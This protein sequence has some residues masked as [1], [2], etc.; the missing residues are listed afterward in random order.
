VLNTHL[1]AQTVHNVDIGSDWTTLFIFPSPTGRYTY[2]SQPPLIGD[3]IPA[4]G[5][6]ITTGWPVIAAAW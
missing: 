2:E 1:C 5:S 4:D 6:V 3:P